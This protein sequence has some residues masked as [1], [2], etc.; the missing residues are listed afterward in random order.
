MHVFCCD[1]MVELLLDNIYFY[2][3]VQ[4]FM[5]YAELGLGW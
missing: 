3:N 5:D 2:A 4:L 1:S